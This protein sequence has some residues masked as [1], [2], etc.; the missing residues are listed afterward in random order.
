MSKN[1]ANFLSEWCGGVSQDFLS[2]GKLLRGLAA[3]ARGRDLLQEM[4]T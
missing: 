3:R 4:Q 2:S 1:Y